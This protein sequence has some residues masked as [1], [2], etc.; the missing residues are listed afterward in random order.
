MSPTTNPASKPWLRWLRRLLVVVLVVLLV[1]F[2]GGGWY[3]SGRIRTDGLLVK[4]YPVERNL[5]LTASGDTVSISSTDPHE[6]RMLRAPSTYGLKW[7]GGYGRVSGPVVSQTRARVVRRFELVTGTAP[8]EG[9]TAEIDLVAFPDDPFYA[10]GAKVEDVTYQSPRG[11][12][13]AWFVAGRHPAAKTWAILVHGQG[14]SRVEMFRMTRATLAAGLPSLAITYRND[15]GQPRDHSG[16]YQ[17]GITEWR[18]LEGA[19]AYAARHGAER[20]CSEPRAWAGASLP[21][22]SATA[23][24]RIFRSSGWCW[25]R[26]CSTSARPSASVPGSWRYR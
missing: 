7:K 15:E 5:T 18:D 13:A 3:F 26:R 10:L 22:T 1:F 6:A 19:V 25:I 21:P 9:T 11:R 23:T 4:P 2:A 20:V 16:Y 8:A 17:Y 14:G 24:R 12:F